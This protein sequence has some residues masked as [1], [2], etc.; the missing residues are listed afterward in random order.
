MNG[1]AFVIDQVHAPC[2]KQDN[3]LRCR[4]RPRSGTGVNIPESSSQKAGKAG[5]KQGAELNEAWRWIVAMST[6]R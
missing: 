6:A 2:E 3:R 5:A 1:V 4:H